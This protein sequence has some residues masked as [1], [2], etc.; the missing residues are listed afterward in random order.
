MI[1]ESNSLKRMH[2]D[3][4]TWNN[5]GGR[6]E[7]I[8]RF[9]IFY[10]YLSP[11]SEFTSFPGRRIFLE[12]IESAT[13]CCCVALDRIDL[14]SVHFFKQH[15]CILFIGYI[16]RCP[17]PIYEAA[18]CSLMYWQVHSTKDALRQGGKMV[19]AFMV[20]TGRQRFEQELIALL[21][22]LKTR[23]LNLPGQMTLLDHG[24]NMRN[25]ICRQVDST[26]GAGDF[27]FRLLMEFMESKSDTNAV[28]VPMA[29][30]MQQYMI[31]N[32]KITREHGLY[33][34][35]DWM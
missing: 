25:W 21:K 18:L 5:R 22:R 2:R 24:S 31:G 27:G 3:K 30:L 14:I 28:N 32:F 4:V 1:S 23:T 13:N 34:A 29:D 19:L 12:W 33:H 11:A 9:L 26:N 6:M 10:G 8:L 17:Q 35:S 15:E 7:R 16:D 20:I